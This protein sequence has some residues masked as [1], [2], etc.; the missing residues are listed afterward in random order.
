M[1]LSIKQ[2]INKGGKSK[3]RAL[4]L[5]KIQLEMRDAEVSELAAI[6]WDLLVGT[7]YLKEVAYLHLVEGSSYTDIVELTGA[8]IHT[9]RTEIYREKKRFVQDMSGDVLE[10]IGGREFTKKQT[11]MYIEVAKNLLNSQ[12]SRNLEVDIFDQLNV[13]LDAYTYV[14]DIELSDIDFFQHSRRLAVISKNYVAK[15]LDTVGSNDPDI[16]GYIKYLL[17][18]DE[19]YLNERDRARRQKLLQ[20]WWLNI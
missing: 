5:S 18:T 2:F 10:Y 13:R 12:K 9:V 20:D 16:I 7:Y 17:G 11:T 3:N 8:N 15:V 6:L 19:K 14:R 1:S 4:M